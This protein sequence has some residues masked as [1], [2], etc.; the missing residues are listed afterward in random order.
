MSL[1]LNEPISILKEKISSK[2]FTEYQAFNLIEP[3]INIKIDILFAKLMQLLVSLLGD[4]ANKVPDL[5][6]FI[7][8]WSQLEQRKIDK[9]KI[10]VQLKHWFIRNSS[11]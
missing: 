11:K 2:E 6:K 7:I 5:K 9:N 10:N 8:D 1:L 4:K 3:D